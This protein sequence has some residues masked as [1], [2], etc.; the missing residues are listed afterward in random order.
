MEPSKYESQLFISMNDA[1]STKVA[2]VNGT[3]YV[4]GGQAT[5]QSGQDANTWSECTSSE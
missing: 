2:N 4:Y 3:V 1:D 5:Q